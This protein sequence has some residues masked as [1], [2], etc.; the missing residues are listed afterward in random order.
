VRKY[1]VWPLFIT[2]AD[3]KI[4]IHTHAHLNI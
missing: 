3:K 2:L 1:E 4:I